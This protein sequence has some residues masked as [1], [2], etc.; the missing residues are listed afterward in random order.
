MQQLQTL[1]EVTTFRHMH[2]HY[3]NLKLT[4]AHCIRR[5][6]PQVDFDL[7]AVVPSLAIPIGCPFRNPHSTTPVHLCC[8]QAQALSS[9]FRHV[10]E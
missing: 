4:T 3:S 6:L 7:S 5:N 10:D 8:P 1:P 2:I 9:L